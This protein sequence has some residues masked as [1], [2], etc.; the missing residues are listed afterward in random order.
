MTLY[1][2]L[3][4]GLTAEEHRA[5]SKEEAQYQRENPPDPHDSL[6]ALGL[7]EGPVGSGANLLNSSLYMLEGKGKEALWEL[8]GAIPVIGM[9]TPYLKGLTKTTKVLEDS[10]KYYTNHKPHSPLIGSLNRLY[11]QA[12]QYIGVV[13][14]GKVLKQIKNNPGGAVKVMEKADQKV[15]NRIDKDLDDI[16]AKGGE[17]AGV[18]EGF[19]KVSVDEAQDSVVK[20]V[21]KRVVDDM[22]DMNRQ[23][24]E[25]GG[26]ERGRK[27]SGKL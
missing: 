19:R 20:G 27:K 11:N 13:R 6:T 9:M 12:L 25:L 4:G 1:Q 3:S 8:T 24:S 16:I 22:D 26:L 21:S 5:V 2:M 10:F 14:E 18:I 17:E 23:F 7:M 15:L